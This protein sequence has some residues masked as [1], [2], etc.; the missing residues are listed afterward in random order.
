[1]KTIKNVC[2][3]GSGVMGREIALNAACHGYGAALFDAMPGAADIALSWAA[4]YLDKSVEKGKATADERRAALGRLRASTH[5][6]D[7]VGGADLVIEAIVE[8]PEAKRELFAQVSAV[9]SGEAIITSNSSYLP[10]SLFVDA[11]KNPQRLANL[12]YFNPAMRMQLVEI[13]QG[14]HT[15]LPTIAS[16]QAFV[17]GV[18]K[19]GIMVKKEIEGFIVNRILRA[20]MNEA[21]YL[22]DNNVASVEDIDLAAE[23]GLNHPLGPFRL[24][25]LT[26]LDI[27]YLSRKRM[28]KESG[29]EADKPIR[30]LEEKYLQ[31]EFGRKAGKGWYDYTG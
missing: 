19:T 30:L 11:V 8:K 10:S 23:K 27:T 25:D 22:L 16:L 20:I 28:H 12:H 31:G 7:G 18:G 21:M 13:V 14:P 4:S 2:V 5:L 3:I 9:A 24:M 1:M 26:G 29:R 17:K 15:S 6:A